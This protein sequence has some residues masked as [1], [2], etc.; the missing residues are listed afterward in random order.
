MKNLQIKR[1]VQ[2]EVNFSPSQWGLY[3]G[4]DGLSE[5]AAY[6]LN[7]EVEDC[8]NA[9]YTK[10]NTRHFVRYAMQRFSEQGA[11]DSEPHRFLEQVLDEI[12]GQPP[13]VLT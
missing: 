13:G 6:F 7:R 9:G 11:D 10:E 12:Y 2:I 8:I 4:A 3:T 5:R 1:I